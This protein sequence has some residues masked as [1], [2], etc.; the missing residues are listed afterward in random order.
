MSSSDRHS[1]GQP[2]AVDAADNA[3]P[4]PAPSPALVEEL[5]L[6]NHILFDQGVVDA[7]GHISVRND[8]NPQRFLLA[9][10]MAPGTV[11]AA[12]IV[13]FTLDGDPVNAN[14][15]KVYLER[16]IH[17]EVMRKR[18]DV[19][20][21]V[22]SH[23]HSIVPLSVSKGTA[24]RAIFHMA[25]FIGT[26]APLFEIR[27]AGGNGTD[28]LISNNKLGRALADLFDGHDIALMRGHGSTV[29]GGSIRQAVYRAVYAEMNAR[30]QL[31]ASMLGEVTFLT[32]EECHACVT[33]VEAQVQRPW[34]LWKTEAQ[35]RRR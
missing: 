25:G 31:Q 4:G 2:I 9:R 15:R 6:A 30:Y 20:A 12:D 19:M 26:K 13:E 24:L 35:Q 11:T 1:H 18:P 10:N 23:S 34:D 29:V 21:V 16:F 3:K 28:L 22:H 7:F 8:N 14:G 5:V 17:G 33:N 27:E 32:A